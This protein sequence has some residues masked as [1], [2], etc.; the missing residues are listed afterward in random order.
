MVENIMSYIVVDEI[1]NK[2]HSGFPRDIST[3]SE[4]VIHGTGGGT[5]AQ[6]VIR[7]MLGGERAAEYSRGVAL[8]HFEIDINGDIYEIIDPDRWVY[9]SGSG[10]HDMITIGI[11]LVNPAKQNQGPYTSE[12]YAGLISLLF[13]YMARR[14]RIETITGHGVNQLQF[15]KIYKSCPG[16]DFDW[17]I[18]QNEL[19]SRGYTF[20]TSTERIY[21]I[22]SET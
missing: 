12:Q 5:S 18:L 19:L 3:I 8:F 9:H 13:D 14:Y 11:E 6:N 1:R 7:W 4:I 16:P 10:K 21:H 20:D 15:S 17:G 2:Y 22:I